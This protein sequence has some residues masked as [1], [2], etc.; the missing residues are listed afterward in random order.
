MSAFDVLSRFGT[1]ALLRFLGAV[2]LFVLL[3][4]LR[5]PVYLLAKV[6]EIGMRRVDGALQRA[7][8]AAGSGKPHNDFFAPSSPA[9]AA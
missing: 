7:V 9:P 5:I 3:H 2:V 6:L 4:V 1:A 8:S